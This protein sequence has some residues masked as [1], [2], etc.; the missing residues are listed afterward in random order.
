MYVRYSIDLSIVLLNTV[1]T[2]YWNAF[3]LVSLVSAPTGIVNR[4][5]WRAE[6][7][8]HSFMEIDHKFLR[9][10]LLLKISYIPSGSRS[11]KTAPLNPV[12]KHQ[13]SSIL[14]SHSLITLE[15]N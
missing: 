11:P 4:L 7:R 12:A 3:I 15:K 6:E 8:S 9:T 5:V 13:K 1:C 2:K 14:I 10:D